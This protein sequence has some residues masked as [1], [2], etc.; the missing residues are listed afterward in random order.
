MASSQQS[1]LRLIIFYK[2]NKSKKAVQSTK[3]TDYELL[4][5]EQTLT[6]ILS[7]AVFMCQ[8]R[9]KTVPLTFSENFERISHGYPTHFSQF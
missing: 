2:Q 5:I 9:N 4:T 7:A 8:I 1:L 6:N 3:S